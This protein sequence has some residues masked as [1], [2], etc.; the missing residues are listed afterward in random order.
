LWAW[1]SPRSTCSCT[2]DWRPWGD[3]WAWGDV[4]ECWPFWSE[5]EEL[6]GHTGLTV[7]LQ[8]REYFMVQDLKGSHNDLVDVLSYISL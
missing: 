4:A 1:P 6:S 7:C 8:N 5:R 3:R 2:R